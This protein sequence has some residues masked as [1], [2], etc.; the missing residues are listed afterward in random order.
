MLFLQYDTEKTEIMY[1]IIFPGDDDWEVDLP[2]WEMHP[3]CLIERVDV[4]DKR[5]GYGT[6]GLKEFIANI[7]EEYGVTRFF[8]HAAYEPVMFYPYSEEGGFEGYDPNNT[9]DHIGRI[10]NFY[11]KVGF[12]KI[13]EVVSNDLFVD[14]YLDI[15]QNE[16]VV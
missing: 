13:D 4:S 1:R 7:G 5:K 15:G 9:K 10:V 8:L 6:K 11:E 12:R 14:M 2:E 16:N 3:Y